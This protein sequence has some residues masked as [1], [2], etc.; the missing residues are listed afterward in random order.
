M[1][2]VEASGFGRGSYPIEVGFVLAQGSMFC[3]LIQPAAD[4]LH[5]DA[6]A[7]SLHGITRAML[8]AHGKPAAYVAN[9]LNTRLRGLTVYCDGWGNDF[10]W[11]ARLF[12]SV[13]MQPSF[14]L[15]DLRCL[16]SEDEAA[17]WHDVTA[18]VRSEQNLRRHRASSDARV[19]QLAMARVR[20]GA[21]PAAA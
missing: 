11:L 18:A 3:A 13:G 16:L 4:W 20:L 15:E 14:R 5:W 12:D 9:Q 19:L 7:E 17:R 2:D 8:L 1:L 6:S 21:T 10:V